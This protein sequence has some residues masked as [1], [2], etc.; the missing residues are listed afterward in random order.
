MPTFTKAA[1]LRVTAT[2]FRAA[3][4]PEDLAAQVAD[5]LVDNHLAGHD[6][7]GILRIPEYLTSIAAGEIQP[8]ARPQI[9]EETA[10]TALVTGNWA[11]GQVTGLYAVDLAITQL[12][13]GTKGVHAMIPKSLFA[14]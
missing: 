5:V 2:I 6:S 3:R 10:T 11:L 8:A 7:H 9:L 14:K 1:L 4:A 12:V 13:D